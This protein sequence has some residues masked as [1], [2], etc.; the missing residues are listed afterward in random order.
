MLLIWAS[1]KIEKCH[2]V[3]SEDM[4]ASGSVKAPVDS[5]WGHPR[6]YVT[7]SICTQEVFFNTK[8]CILNASIGM[9]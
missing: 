4:K 8:G 9:A 3:K 1:L 2:L 5:A 7:E 6:Y